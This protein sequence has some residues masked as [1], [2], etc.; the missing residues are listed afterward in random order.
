M[1]SRILLLL[2][3]ALVVSAC[4]AAPDIPSSPAHALTPIRL[5]MG[6][7]P[8]PQF[9]PVYVANYKGYFAEENIA[10]EFD[11]SYETDGIALVG[12]EQLSFTLGSGEQAIMARAKGLP[13]VY[14]MQWFQEYPIAVIAKQ[15]AGIKTPTDLVGRQ[16]GIPGF[17][18]ASYV[19]FEGLL[20]AASL[21]DGDVDL[22]EIGFTQAEALAQDQVEAAVVYV[23]NEPVRLRLQGIA[24]D[25]IDVADYVDMV[26]NGLMTNKATVRD[27]PELVEGMVRALLRGLRDVLA[28]PDEAFNICKNYVEGLDATPEAEQAQRAVL[29]AS[30]DIWRAPRLGMSAAEAWSNT[31]EVLLAIDFVQ[32]PVDLADVWTNQFVEAAGVR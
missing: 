3:C 12:A 26:G 19:G 6:Y 22:V 24:L 28:D 11:Y 25:V 21:T 16:I 7:I 17:F 15:E 30:L 23:N 5:P 4:A 13:I 32:E 1:K 18:G 2:T 27:H 31:Q 29:Q 10:I 20:H 14:V 8:D 9:A